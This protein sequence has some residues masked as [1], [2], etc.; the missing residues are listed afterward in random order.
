MTELEGAQGSYRLEDDPIGVGGQAEVWGGTRADGAKVAVKVAHPVP[1]ARRALESET[2]LLLQ[3]AT[4]GCAVPCWDTGEV[5]GRPALVMPRAVSDVDALVRARIA[6]AMGAGLLEVL[7]VV[8][9]LCRKLALLHA[10]GPAGGSLVHRDVKPENVL[11]SPEG[12]LWLCDFGGSLKVEELRPVR[13]GLF[14]SPLWAPFDQMLPG[15]P[16]PNPTWDT[17]A[18]CV[19]LFWWL[20]GGRPE[21]QEDPS[22][23]LTARGRE[24]WDALRAMAA[25]ESA[26]DR[27]EAMKRLL[28]AQEGASAADLVDVRGHAAIQ[29]GDRAAIAAGV[30]RLADPL[31]FGQNALD[32][33][34]RDLAD[35][36]AR[37]LSPLSHPSPP[38]RYWR[39][40]ELADEIDAV[41]ERLR[42]AE[43]A[44]RGVAR[45][46]SLERRVRSLEANR[47]P[48][49][50][51]PAVLGGGAL[52]AGAGVLAVV[53]AAT[54]APPGPAEP[55]DTVA[56][57]AA[58]FP[59]GD[60]FGDGDDDERPVK[61]VPIA[62]YR[63]G[64]TEVTNAQW[65]ACVEAGV[66]PALA[67]EG[68]DYVGLD[69]DG[70][71]VVGATWSEAGTY[72]AWAGGRLPSEA[73]WEMA[74]TWSPEAKTAADKRRW[75]WGSDGPTCELANFGT[76]E[77]GVTM[78][79]GSLPKGASAYGA[80]D[81]VGNAWEWTAGSYRVVRRN[82]FR[83]VEVEEKVLRGGAYNSKVAYVRP[84]FRRHDDPGT[85]SP[86][87]SF[88]CVFSG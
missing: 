62:A 8:S 72:C 80:L 66:C 85:R 53:I 41:A 13:L 36:M 30:A 3:L 29:E 64:R 44:L 15:L 73:E 31:R 28:Q 17:Y 81:M 78:L 38:N 88:R 75:P 26:V 11:V 7:A 12:G 37:G 5:D 50:V 77:R 83:R 54:R 87:Y 25:A 57:A 40:S 43:A 74:A 45:N 82:G 48:A 76:C 16:E 63:I 1:S 79:A 49:W 32:H 71:P 19:M 34:A 60:T 47:R 23:M 4:L 22:P 67:Q 69:R 55:S 51:L 46:Q 2:Q 39:A 61:D 10:A 35:V 52:V 14:G 21:Y 68:P 42:G 70:Q 59:L 84:T 18:A 56:V 86:L 9:E 20:T 33:A 27:L 24:A 65:R 58:T 6:G